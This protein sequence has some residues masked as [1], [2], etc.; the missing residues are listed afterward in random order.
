MQDGPYTVADLANPDAAANWAVA[1]PSHCT[2]IKRHP[3]GRFH[4]W[5]I[6]PGNGDGKDKNCSHGGAYDSSH[7]PG[8]GA[9]GSSVA[10]SQT[11]WVHT[12]PTP[13]GP[14]DKVG[15]RIEIAGLINGTTAA[16]SWCS[17]G[18]VRV[19]VVWTAFK[20]IAQPQPTPHPL[21]APLRLVPMLIGWCLGLMGARVIRCCA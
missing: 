9:G 19:D 8:E 13:T 15:T 20:R 17:C 3:S 18:S 1:P 6:L 2:Q 11:L 14:W 4:L 21:C 7:N 12:A 16:Q 5:H 10:F